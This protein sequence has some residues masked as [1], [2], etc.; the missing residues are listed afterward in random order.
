MNTSVDKQSG[1]TNKPSN[2]FNDSSVVTVKPLDLDEIE[3]ILYDPHSLLNYNKVF[4][5]PQP[6]RVA[7]NDDHIF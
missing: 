6:S 2:T 7:E 4:P 1:P 5:K 3:R